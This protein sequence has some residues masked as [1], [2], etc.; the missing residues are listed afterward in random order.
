MSYSVIENFAGGVDR[1]RP[2]YVMPPGT[3]WTGINGH[4]SRGGDFE[5]RKAF[6]GAYNLPGGTFGLAKNSTGLVVFGSQVPPTMPSGVTY[7]RLQHGV[8]VMTKLLSWDLYNGQ[9][10][11][12]A[13]YN[14]GDVRNFYN[15]TLVADWGAGGT[16][17]SGYAT[18]VRTHRRKVYAGL[19]SVVWGSAIDS[20]T[21]FDT[22]LGAFFQNMSNHQSGSDQIVAMAAFQQLLAI[23]S[24]QVIQIW[25]MQDVAA[26][27]APQQFLLETGTLAA[28][29]V[30]AFGDLDAF[31]LAGTG[32]RSLRSRQYTNVAGV[33]D[34]GTPIDPIILGLFD[35]LPAATV[36]A[37]QSVIDPRDGRFWM[38]IGDKI[39]VFSYFPSKQISAWT[40]YEP[41]YSFTD[42]VTF[43]RQI[44]AREGDVIYL[45]GGSDNN[46]YDDCAVTLDL[47]FLAAKQPATYKTLDGVDLLA[48]NTW[49]CKL[50]V[51]PNDENEFIN[52]GL[53]EGVTVLQESGGAI[54]HT[55]HIAPKLYCKQQGPASVSQVIVHY[56]GAEK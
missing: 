25:N 30:Q 48:K 52:V 56:N 8:N 3:I 7:Q 13:Q 54:G 9:I 34:V 33:N 53:M 32:I 4:I 20:A 10:Y 47:P 21:N 55:T 24:A 26:S 41:G 46:T 50:L 49:D 15:G 29:S 40:W 23:F 44:W 43:N 14:N 18:V 35:T 31:Y 12:I 19:G 17:P 42:V 36:A 45:Y 1:S 37:A 6:V 51:N 28:R 2:R 5:K 39:F 16:K 27:N 22:S 38:V 11:A